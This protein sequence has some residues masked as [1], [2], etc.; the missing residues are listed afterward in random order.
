MLEIFNLVSINGTEDGKIFTAVWG[1]PVWKIPKLF[2]TLNQNYQTILIA[3][4]RHLYANMYLNARH[5]WERP[6]FM[7]PCDLCE[8]VGQSED[9]A[10]AAHYGDC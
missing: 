6:I 4:E 8:S 1:D 7:T 3:Q 9:N 5:H 10:L 2:G